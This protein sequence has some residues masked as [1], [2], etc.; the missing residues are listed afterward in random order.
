[1]YQKYRNDRETFYKRL[2]VNF[3]M[4]EIVRQSDIG[5]KRSFDPI[6][7][8][9]NVFDRLFGTIANQNVDL[10]ALTKITIELNCLRSEKENKK[11]NIDIKSI[12]SFLFQS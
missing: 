10:K 5:E 7:S 1:M 2:E 3:K 6:R 9:S 4:G 11:L 12:N 8:L